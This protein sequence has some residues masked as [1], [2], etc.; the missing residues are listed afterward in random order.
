MRPSSPVNTLLLAAV[1]ALGAQAPAAADTTAAQTAPVQTGAP[2]VSPNSGAVTLALADPGVEDAVRQFYAARLDSPVWHSGSHWIPAAEAM[3]QVLSEADRHG[4][5]PSDYLAQPPATVVASAP[6]DAQDVALTDAALRYLRD[7]TAGRIA[8]RD[9]PDHRYPHGVPAREAAA[10]A[11]LTQAL[12]GPD[13][14]AALAAVQP[15]DPAYD[16][17]KALLAEL[18]QQQMATGGWPPVPDGPT[19]RE[20]EG[21]GDDR[22]P[23]L[24]A[25]LLLHG[26]LAPADTVKTPRVFDGSLVAA[27]KRFQ[28]RHGI[29]VDGV[30]G[31]DTLKTLNV[32]LADRIMQVEANLERMR[33]DPAPPAT[34][35]YIEVNVA[36]YRLTAY[37]DGVPELFMSVVVGT[38]ENRTPLFTD[39]M[40]DVVLNPTWTVP[41]SIARN[42][43]LPRLRADPGYT[44]AENM[45][46]HA[47]WSHSAPK[48][49]PW[50]VDWWSVQ[51]SR[52]PYMFVER[53]G[54]GNALGRVRFSLNNDF[55]IYMHDTPAKSLFSRPH[56]AFSHGCVRVADYDRLLAFVADDQLERLRRLLDSGRTMTMRL[57]QN[58]DVRVLYHSAWVDDLGT[59]HFRRDVYGLDPEVVQRMREG[60]RKLIAQQPQNVGLN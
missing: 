44:I 25:S 7:V 4:L 31:P 36:D 33:W 18:R 30:L 41:P 13:P 26:D 23:L 51:G 24:Q 34:G 8:P 17:L 39:Y 55:A 47:S 6:T 46:I 60:S 42:E 52:M 11:L 57:P 43:I 38:D 59:P 22:L 37:R 45:D 5:V 21:L 12:A 35:K 54:P 53:A 48:I 3:L 32:P 28:A 29:T 50:A 2:L 1:L 15:A 27:L 56:R 20:G 9:R 14:A 49:D 40:D 19:L 10:A 16:R 58:V